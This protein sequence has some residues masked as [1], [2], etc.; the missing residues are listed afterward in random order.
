[1]RQQYAWRSM[2]LNGILGFIAVAIVLQMVRIQASAEADRF[3]EQAN[4]FAGEF[5]WYFPERGAIYDRN[6]HLLAGNQTVYEVGV[7]LVTVR[8]PHTIALTL[9]V[10]LGRDYDE[11]HSSILNPPPDLSYVVIDKYVPVDIAEH[12]MEL[13]KQVAEESEGPTP[14]LAGL[15]FVARLE[16]NYPEGALAS[17]VI[18]FV[19]RAGRGYFGVEE[20]YNDLLAG[21]PVQVWVPSDPNRAIE[22]PRILNGTTLILT[23]NRSLQS[24]V[25]SILQ[26]ALEKYAAQN[27]TIVVM[28]PKNGEILAMAS[29]PNMDLNQFWNYG[30]TY[31][32]ASEFNRAISNPYEPGSVI[33]I[34]TMASAFDTGTVDL[35]TTFLDTGGFSIAGTTIRNWD[36]QSWGVQNML[37]C[38]QNSLNVCLAWVATQLG[39][40]DFYTY[41]DRFGFGRLTGVDLSGEAAGRLKIP[42]DQDWY[43]IDLGTNSYGQGIA[44]TPLQIMMAATAIANNG[45]M[46]TPHILYAMVRDGNQFN[47]PPQYAGMPISSQTAGIMNELLAQSLENQPS[48]AL[49][50]GYRIAGK[51]G[52]ASI[53]TDY[54]F[55]DLSQTNA[56]FIGWGPADDPQFMVYVWLER[57]GVSIWG[58][59]TAAPVFATVAEKTVILLDIPPD[60]IRRQLK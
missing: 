41:M 4:E 40:R 24:E 29:T 31:D 20:K 42:G 19:N 35:S 11:I 36:R 23:I 27:G 22:I 3:R 26:Q 46:V 60:N 12:L 59:E 2:F 48:L 54:G 45:R 6:G 44:A 15:G 7:D 25:E 14:S 43:P 13:K 55:Y 38:I 17:N 28:N 58:S 21:N 53:P 32:N 9:S 51:T 49:V 16:R 1:M 52:T 34:F 50:D 33:K 10:N 18:G 30:E 8:D 37:G 57:P 39:A 5:K 56:S 47:V